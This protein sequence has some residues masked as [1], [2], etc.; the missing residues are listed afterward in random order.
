MLIL[1]RT[2]K[3]AIGVLIMVESGA[4]LSGRVVRIGYM[5]AESVWGQGIATELLNG[6]VHWCKT[7][8]V[9]TVMGGVERDN[10]S[11]RRVLEKTGFE[12]QPEQSND[13]ELQYRLDIQ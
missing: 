10:I 2:S 6:F 7:V 13:G 3:N 9:S 12:V 8:G 4:E 11:S 5:L 1:D